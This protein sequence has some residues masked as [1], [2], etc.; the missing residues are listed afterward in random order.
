V[1]DLGNGLYQI[2]QLGWMHLDM[3]SS[4]IICDYQIFKLADFGTLTKVGQFA[5]GKEGAG[6]YVLVEALAF[7]SGRN[8]VNVQTDIPLFLK[9]LTGR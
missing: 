7:P 9:R 4:N 3:S 8:P 5:E 2:H 1:H 6:P